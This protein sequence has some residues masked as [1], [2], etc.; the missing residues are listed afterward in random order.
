MVTD[1]WGGV[2]QPVTR[3]PI[4]RELAETAGDASEEGREFQLIMLEETTVGSSLGY[5]IDGGVWRLY[6]E[7]V[8]IAKGQSFEAKAVRYGFKESEIAGRP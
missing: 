6:N 7:P 2:V 3:P 8:A 5:R 1:M 4:I